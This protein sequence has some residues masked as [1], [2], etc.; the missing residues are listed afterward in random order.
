M[1]IHR[2]SLRHGGVP[3]PTLA[4]REIVGTLQLTLR[5]HFRALAG[6]FVQALAWCDL[7]RPAVASEALLA[8]PELHHAAALRVLV[9]PLGVVSYPLAAVL[10]PSARVAHCVDRARLLEA[11]PALPSVALL[12]HV[13]ELH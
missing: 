1:V 7:L 12:A 9:Q 6:D 13:L 10:G 5:L 2:L 11:G 8:A 4:P 3:V